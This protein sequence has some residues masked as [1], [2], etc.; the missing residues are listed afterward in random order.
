MIIGDR[1]LFLVGN[2]LLIA[3]MH[4]GFVR[5]G[6]WHPTERQTS[7]QADQFVRTEAFEVLRR[8]ADGCLLVLTVLAW[9]MDEEWRL[10]WWLV[11]D[12]QD[13]ARRVVNDL[14]R[15]HNPQ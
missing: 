4:E 1:M 12:A 9:L 13:A 5:C 15:T 14:I 2:G 6:R 11:T 8:L 10:Q 7:R 3:L